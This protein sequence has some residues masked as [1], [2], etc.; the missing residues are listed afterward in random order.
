MKFLYM[1][2]LIKYFEEIIG[3]IAAFVMVSVVILNV[4]LRYIFS[5]SL[6][7][8][9]EL[10]VACFIWLIFMGA[11]ACFKHKMHIGIE[12][13]VLF[14]PKILHKHVA[15]LIDLFM[16]VLAVT[17]VILSSQYTFTSNKPTAI[18]GVSYIY[19]NISVTVSFFLMCIHAVRLLIATIRAKDF[20]FG[21]RHMN[22]GE[23]ER[24]EL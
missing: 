8:V 23:E 4:I 19:I 5:F 1:K 20:S 13:M 11:S 3:G 21:E 14:L 16:I 9:E 22:V 12:V 15:I 17:T 10:S 2:F 24:E 18:L 7:F 6:E